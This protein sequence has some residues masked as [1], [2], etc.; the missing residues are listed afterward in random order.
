MFI[1]YLPMIKERL[2]RCLNG[3]L[4]VFIMLFY[5]KLISIIVLTMYLVDLLIRNEQA[6][7]FITRGLKRIWLNLTM[8]AFHIY[9][10]N[11][12]YICYD[13][14]VLTM[15]RNIVISN[16]MTEYDWLFILTVLY[17]LGRFN[18]VCIIL[19]QSLRKIPLLGFGM[20]FFGFIFLNRKLSMDEQIIEQGVARLVK[21]QKYDLLVFPEGTYIDSES[22]RKTTT[23]GINNNIMVDNKPFRP[24]NVLI[25]RLSGFKLLTKNLLSDI[26]GI[27]NITMMV[28]PHE[29][30]PQEVYSYQDTVLNFKGR[31]NSVFYIDFISNKKEIEDDEFLYKVFQEKDKM[32]EKFKSLYNKYVFRSLQDFKTKSKTIRPVR[33][34]DKYEIVSLKSKWCMFFY[35]TFILG[36]IF[37]IYFVAS[38]FKQTL[39]N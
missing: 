24:E 36:E 34:Q 37:L 13:P 39:N 16:H 28:T 18:D 35:S 10:P 14:A 22:Y 1:E 21:R 9:F 27:I 6:K 12:I 19:K 30:F 26:D 2:R 17:R 8:S 31:I 7:I 29:H 11:P 15:K 38:F 32:I 5:L 20:E 33:K 4:F 25:P 23:F 3:A